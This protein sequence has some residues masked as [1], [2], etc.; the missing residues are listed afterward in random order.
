MILDASAGDTIADV[1]LRLEAGLRTALSYEV[2][3]F[4]RSAEQ[5]RAIAA[6]EP[7]DADELAASTGKPQVMLLAQKP[8]ATARRAALALAPD[9]DLF[10]FEADELHWLPGAGLSDTDA[11]LQGPGE[12][13]RPRDRPHEGHDRADRREALRGLSDDG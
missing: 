4:A 13:D 12:G 8:S 6:F 1:A 5:V 10:A 11:R 2:P 7:F 9:D 3:V